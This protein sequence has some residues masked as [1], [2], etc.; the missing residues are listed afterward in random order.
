MSFGVGDGRER[1]DMAVV[2]QQRVY[3]DAALGLAERSPWEKRQA[4]LD[5]GGVQTEQLGFEA[6]VV[7]RGFGRA[8]AVHFG[9]Q[10]LEKSHGPGVVGVGKGGAGHVFQPPRIQAASGRVQA[11][12][13][14]AHGAPCGKL[15]EGHGCELLP[16]AEFA[17]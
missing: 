12:Q 14:V 15:D 7:F 11:T 9:E 2:I 17:R 3:L 10:I 13:A 4:K 5:G 1:R 8:Q 6:K 16:E